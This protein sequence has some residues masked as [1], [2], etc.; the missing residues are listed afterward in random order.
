M[1]RPWGLLDLSEKNHKFLF[2]RRAV[3][4]G[5][6]DYSS[7]LFFGK[8]DALSLTRGHRTSGFEM[9]LLNFVVIPAQS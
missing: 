7:L 2:L 9:S 4:E 1:L 8:S 5:S 3:S 6:G